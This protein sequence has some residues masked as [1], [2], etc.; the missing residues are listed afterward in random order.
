[1]THIDLNCDMGETPG[2]QA[3]S[4]DGPLLEYV[5]SANIACG[6]HAGDP[7]RML[8]TVQAAARKGVAIGAHP[9]LP[10]TKGFGRR[11]RPITP[12][13]V[14]EITLY[15]TGALEAFV[16]AAGTSLHHVKPHGA[17]YNMAARDAALA[18]ALVSAIYDFDH[19]L[20]IYALAGSE[21][22]KAA[23]AKGL[24][25]AAEGFIDRTY[26]SDGTLTPRNQTGAVIEDIPQ[27]VMQARSLAGRVDTLCLHGD[28]TLALPMIRAVR[29]ALVQDGILINAPYCI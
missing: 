6:F 12:A 10:D 25:V 1:M 8:L 19:S 4:P 22:V 9:G 29:D 18:E 24:R 23:R 20:V 21:M 28:G 16:R 2:N 27:A 5:S 15:Q 3:G 13:E 7:R 26:R 11:E 14:Y 17:L